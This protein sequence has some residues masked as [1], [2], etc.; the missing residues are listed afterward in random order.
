MIVHL[1]YRLVKPMIKNCL[2]HGSKVQD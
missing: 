1:R 2:L